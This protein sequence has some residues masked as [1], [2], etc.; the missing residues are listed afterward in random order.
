MEAEQRKWDENKS[1]LYKLIPNAIPAKRLR[2]PKP[3]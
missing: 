1:A 2:K 3:H